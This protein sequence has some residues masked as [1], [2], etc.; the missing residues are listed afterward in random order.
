MNRRSGL[1]PVTS[2]EWLFGVWL[3]IISAIFF[4]SAGVFT[5][6]VSADAWTIIFWRG[7]FAAACGFIYLLVIGRLRDEVRDFKTPA[8][9]LAVIYASGTAAFIPAFKLTSIAN[10]ALIWSSAPVLAGSLGWLLFGQ[11]VSFGF[12]LACIAVIGGTFIIVYGS[13]GQAGLT[14]DL[15]ALWM[16]LMMVLIMMIYRR[17]P[18][19]P[20]TLPTVG[21]SL[22]LLP[23]SWHFSD[24]LSAAPDEIALMALFGI[25]FVIAS[26]TLAQGS[27]LVMPGETALLSISESPWAIILAILFLA[28]WPSMQ[29]VIGGTVILSAVLW[30]QVMA[31]RRGV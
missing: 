8:I 17:F 7:L 1:R 11:R 12:V 20:T 24:P 16:T 9:T 28:E 22:F 27:K 10:V 25:T 29:T 3:V 4:S 21:A 23:I 18:E 19:T 5:K 31:L 15:L 26:I 6:G 30:Y 14:G 2:G 13:F